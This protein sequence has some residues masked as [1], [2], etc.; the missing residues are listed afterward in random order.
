MKNPTIKHKVCEYNG[1]LWAIHSAER[2]RS[3]E[4]Y[5]DVILRL[6]DGDEVVF[7]EMT[8]KNYDAMNSKLEEQEF[9]ITPPSL[10]AEPAYPPEGDPVVIE[11][12]GL[13]G[14]VPPNAPPGFKGYG[15]GTAKAVHPPLPPQRKPWENRRR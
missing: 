13:T 2:K 15:L 9:S 6:V 1:R 8:W 10:V 14:F 5:A 3:R 12:F 7:A 11:A 4:G